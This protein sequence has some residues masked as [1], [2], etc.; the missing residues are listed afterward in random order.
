MFSF[1]SFGIQPD[2]DCVAKGL[3]CGYSPIAATITKEEIAKGF[4]YFATFAWSPLACKTASVILDEYERLDLVKNSENMGIKALFELRQGIGSN[5]N[6]REIR[7]MGLRI[8][9][10]FNNEDFFNKIKEKLLIKG[11]FS[12]SADLPSILTISPPLCIS[13]EDMDY[14]VVSIVNC[15]N[16]E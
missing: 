3:G 14:V 2:I 8:S 6:V 11:I 4:D 5:P 15:I 12:G 10:E 7:G 9:I 16:N 13:S 1:D